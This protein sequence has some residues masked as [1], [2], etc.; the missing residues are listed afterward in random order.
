M[1]KNKII[2]YIKNIDVLDKEEISQIDNLI[3]K[4]PYFQ[5]SYLILA[6]VLLISESIRYN[7]FFYPTAA[8]NLWAIFTFFSIN[9][10]MLLK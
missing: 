8:L 9:A 4:Y 6:K 5:S 10:E 2:S 1:K 3:L 7:N